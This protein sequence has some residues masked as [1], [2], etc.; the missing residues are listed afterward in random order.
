MYSIAMNT[1]DTHILLSKY[2]YS[3]KERGILRK[4]TLGL[5]QGKY[6]VNLEHIDVSENTK[7]L[8]LIRSC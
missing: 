5:Q 8:R 6:Q 2:H 7:E 4:M 3:L 1:D